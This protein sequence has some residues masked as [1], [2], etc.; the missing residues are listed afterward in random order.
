MASETSARPRATA[1]MSGEGSTKKST[2]RHQSHRSKPTSVDAPDLA[3]LRGA[4]ASHYDRPT[5]E[6]MNEQRRKRDKKNKQ[7]DHISVRSVGS[8]TVRRRRPRVRHDESRSNNDYASVYPSRNLQDRRH[9]D[10]EIPRDPLRS[11][12][13]KSNV[14]DSARPGDVQREDRSGT[15]P[16]TQRRHTTSEIKVA[17]ASTISDESHHSPTISAT[18]KTRRRSS[19]LLGSFFRTKSATAVPSIKFVNCLTCGSDDIPSTKSAKLECGHRM[20]HECLKR[21]FTLSTTDPAH[22]PPKCCT[23]DH[24]PLEPVEALFDNKFKILWNKKYQEYTTKNRLYCP[25]RNCGIWIP[26][27][28]IRRSTTH[29]RKYGTCPRCTTKVCFKCNNRWHKSSPCS[30]DAAT[31]A[32]IATAKDKGW[33][34]CYNC[35]AMVELDQGCNHMTCRCTAEFCM[36]CGV[37]W[38][39]CECPWFNFGEGDR[40]EH[41]RVLEIPQDGAPRT[42]A[43]EQETRRRQERLDELMARRLQVSMALDERHVKEV[44]SRVQEYTWGVG[45]GGSHF[46]N[47][48][49][50][51]TT[52]NVV[53][54]LDETSAGYG[55]R[56]ERESGRRKP[57]TM[58]LGLDAGLAANAFGEASAL[59]IAPSRMPESVVR[60]ETSPKQASAAKGLGGWFS[61]LR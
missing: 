23:T 38:K 59:G 9:G 40:L 57:R 6:R 54:G 16:L 42:F 20:C 24:I 21:L 53:T 12:K 22:M 5:H 36:L 18:Q 51:D 35:H 49:F 8:S 43:D 14:S 1:T 30:S 25:T 26:P 45:N 31:L 61:R 55:R 27:K 33:Q 29:D 37:K 48:N 41:M 52:T 7:E 15:R 34:P 4:R 50:V 2:S 60:K 11:R 32:F 13:T 17:K 58:Y 28:L 56:G 44:P 47:D 39:G 10:Q 19:G 3:E 46:L